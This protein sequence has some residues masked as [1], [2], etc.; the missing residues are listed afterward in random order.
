MVGLKKTTFKQLEN[1]L[2]KVNKGKLNTKINNKG[3]IFA[4]TFL[5]KDFYSDITN[6]QNSTVSPW[7]RKWQPAPVLLPGKSHGGA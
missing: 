2:L 7:R 4:N 3:E 5:T 6:C 1:F